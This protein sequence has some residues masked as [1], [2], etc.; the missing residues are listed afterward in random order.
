[1]SETESETKS[2]DA[3]GTTGPPEE[4]NVLARVVTIF[5]G[6][7]TAAIVGACFAGAYFFFP[8]VDEEPSAV[9][10]VMDGMLDI[11]IPAVFEPR[12][13]IEWNMA[14]VMTMR[15]AYFEPVD[16][17]RNGILLFVQVEGG[18][19]DKPEVR[20]HIEN[21]LWQDGSATEQ[22]VLETESHEE[23][24]V[25]VR[26]D[27]VPFVFET[28]TDAQTK[29]TYRLVHGVV[30]GVEGPVLIALRMQ[31]DSGWNDETAVAML[32]SIR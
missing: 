13:T 27:P 26:G 25:L 14:L 24:M 28:A 11:D 4:R 7:G 22:L 21:V 23:R 20:E 19:G 2:L 6:F 18:S 12:G 32:R 5:L 30:E 8:R 29:T 17:E 9:A 16:S 1:M 31:V 3:G 10:D 15:G